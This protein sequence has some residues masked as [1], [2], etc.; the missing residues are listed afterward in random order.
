[1]PDSPGALRRALGPVQPLLVEGAKGDEPCPEPF[2]AWYDSYQGTG[3][4]APTGEADGYAR[5]GRSEPIVAGRDL[6]G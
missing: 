5:T 4:T 3:D 2:E 1:V 6:L